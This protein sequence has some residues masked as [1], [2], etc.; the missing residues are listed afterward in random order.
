V[1]I[2]NGAEIKAPTNQRIYDFRYLD[3]AEPLRKRG[4]G[5]EVVRQ[6][7]EEQGFDGIFTN[8]PT[9][10][11][12]DSGWYTSRGF[13]KLQQGEEPPDWGE[14]AQSGYYFWP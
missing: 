10:A 1:A 5:T 2:V 4:V 12:R 6:L 3:V 13:R 8:V 11:L 7:K 14:R 9:V